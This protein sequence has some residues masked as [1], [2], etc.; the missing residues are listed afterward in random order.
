M[1]GVL[2]KRL[3]FAAVAAAIVGGF[4]Y[5]LRERPSW[6]DVEVLVEAP[7]KVTVREEGISRVRE[8]YT[9]SA[10][11]AGHLTR[12][13]LKEG[14]P[15][16]AGRTVVASIHPLDP[17]LLD[18]RT[19]AELLAARDAAQSAVAIAEI[20]LQRADAALRLANEE[21][22]RALRLFGPG[23]ITEAALQRAANL[24][25]ILGVAVEAAKATIGFKKAELA[26]VEARLLQPEPTNP[27]GER[28]C[29]NLIAPVDG[30]VLQVLAKS[31]QAVAAGARIAEIGDKRDLE[32]VVD[33]LSADA[34]RIRP[35]TKAVISEWGG[36]VTLEATVRRVEPA[37][38]TKV[39]AL[40]IEEQRVN[41]VLDL[42][43]HDDRLGHGY[44]IFV[45]LAVWECEQCLQVPISALF[46][47]GNRWS[48]FLVQNN[49]LRQAEVEIG[50]MNQEVAELLGGAAPGD[51]VVV[52]P[53]DTLEDGS[54]V[55][56]RH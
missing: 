30:T 25:E 4:A 52:H 54:L 8:V 2:L 51:I 35:G 34:V 26:S 28:C 39:S 41:T 9:V 47:D 11:I 6:V 19:E 49:R 12:T 44:R 22:E 40:G 23:I 43:K 46:R 36:E 18:R 16:T 37:A 42:D 15:V 1:K 3:A 24:A 56:S 31:E 38:F 50:H 27:S 17:P 20:E 53:G 48:V 10:P 29:V 55:A 5:A 33:L 45:E 14:D 32:L 21:R 13:V 7:M